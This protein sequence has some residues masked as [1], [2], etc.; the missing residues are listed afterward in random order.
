MRTRLEVK[1]TVITSRGSKPACS[2]SLR[3]VRVFQEALSGVSSCTTMRS[4]RSC[5]M[6]MCALCASGWLAG[7]ATARLSERQMYS[8][9]SAPTGVGSAVNTKS[10]SPEVRKRATW[11]FS[12]MSSEMSGCAS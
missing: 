8:T 11:L 4:P 1:L 3:S 9:R 10:H 12:A 7:S 5:S 2:H 6:V